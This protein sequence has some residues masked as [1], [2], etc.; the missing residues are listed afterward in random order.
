MNNDDKWF[1]SLGFFAGVLFTIAVW[2]GGNNII[3]HNKVFN[4]YLTYKGSIYT[5]ELH[6]D[7]TEI[8]ET[9]TA[10]KP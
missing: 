2:A 3:E 9:I 6:T 5:V 4:G 8:K 7:V 1:Y 10:G